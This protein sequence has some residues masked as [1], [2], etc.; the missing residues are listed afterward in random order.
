MAP[1]NRQRVFSF[2]AVHLP[3]PPDALRGAPR[4][5]TRRAVRYLIE[6]P[7]IAALRIALPTDA[8]GEGFPKREIFFERR[9]S[10]ARRELPGWFRCCAG[11]DRKRF[12]DWEG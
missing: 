3:E 4:P 12:V 9:Q 11:V 10:F 2:D 7:D 1:P 5:W 6:A 8:A